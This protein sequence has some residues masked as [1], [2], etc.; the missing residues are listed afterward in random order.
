MVHHI[1]SNRF[2]RIRHEE[3]FDAN[4]LRHQHVVLGPFLLPAFQ[5]RLGVVL[6]V[7]LG[8]GLGVVLGLVLGVVVLGVVLGAVLG[9]VLGAVL[10]VVLGVEALLLEQKK[11]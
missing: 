4:A 7:V 1:L 9:V 11:R 8:V 6:G 3:A 10:G 2:D 5:G